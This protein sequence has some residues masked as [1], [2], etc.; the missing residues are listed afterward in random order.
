MIYTLPVRA[1]VLVFGI[2]IVIV[3]SISPYVFS[4]WQHMRTRDLIIILLGAMLIAGWLRLASRTSWRIACDDDQLRVSGLFR[5]TTYHAEEI[6]GIEV[7]ELPDTGPRIFGIQLRRRK[8]S[9]GVLEVR[10]RLTGR[11]SRLLFSDY[12]GE[13][14]LVTD[15]QRGEVRCLRDFLVER[16]GPATASDSENG[17]TK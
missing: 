11:R 16:F 13:P 8:P 15:P 9:V 6:I 4:F 2:A 12:E 10:V 1:K 3:A 14:L 7:K 17:T 5:S